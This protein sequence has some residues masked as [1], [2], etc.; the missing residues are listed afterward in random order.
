MENR[1]RKGKKREEELDLEVSMEAI[2]R[3]RRQ[4]VN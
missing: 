2:R 4:L 3:M 1:E